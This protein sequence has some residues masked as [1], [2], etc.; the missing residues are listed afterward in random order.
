MS[1][2]CCIIVAVL[3]R[4]RRRAAARRAQNFSARPRAAVFQESNMGLAEK[5][6]IQVIAAENIAGI[7]KIADD[8]SAG[9]AGEKRV[10]SV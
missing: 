1:V 10:I 6:Q 9:R 8:V 4:D 3:P 7:G 5:R 2:C